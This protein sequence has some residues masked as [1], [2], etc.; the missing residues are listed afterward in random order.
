MNWSDLLS[1]GEQQRVIFLRL[2]LTKPQ[3][4][5]LDESTSALDE[6][7]EALVYQ[8]LRDSG[9]TYISVGHR[10]SLIDFHDDILALDGQE[11]WA[12]YTQDEYKTTRKNS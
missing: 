10:S 12:L 1:L 7:N 2:L 8:S 6:A 9:T 4:A 3:F 11:G 5:I